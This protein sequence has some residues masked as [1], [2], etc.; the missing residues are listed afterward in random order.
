MNDVGKSQYTIH[1]KHFTINITIIDNKNK[2]TIETII[3]T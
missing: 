3:K 2:R 1:T